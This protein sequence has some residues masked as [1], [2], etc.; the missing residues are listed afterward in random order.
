MI[1]ETLYTYLSANGVLDAPIYTEIPQNPPL[2]FYTME[3]TGSSLTN[4]V[5]SSTFAIQSHA[6]T[7]YH[8][9]SMN[10]EI[11]NVMLDDAIALNEVASI[12]LNSDYNYTDTTSKKYRYQA[13][14][15]VI[16]Y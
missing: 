9:A 4:H 16:H 15:D 13:I 11:K 10:E 1:E 12:R 2:I 14:F 8:A 7:L 3:K 6:D 5:Y